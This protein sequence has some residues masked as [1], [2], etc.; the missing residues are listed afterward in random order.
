MHPAVLW[1]WVVILVVMSL[2]CLAPEKTQL[3]R[4]S[5]VFQEINL[6]LVSGRG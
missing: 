4:L 2:Y 1:F 6:I 3:V 5:R